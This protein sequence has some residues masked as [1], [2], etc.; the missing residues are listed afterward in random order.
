MIMMDQNTSVNALKKKAQDLGFDLVG[1]ASTADPALATEMERYHHW[2]DAGRGASMDYLRRHEPMKANPAL[3]L[4]G[5]RSVIAV[6]MVYGAEKPTASP[7]TAQI[8]L[9]AR[10][11]DY[12]D[13]LGTKLEELAAYARTLEA[14][15]A[16][17]TYVDKE[18]V[19][20]RFWA[21]RAGLGWLGKNTCLIN[22]K[23]GSFLFLGGV[24]TTLD[25][26]TDAPQP[27]HCGRC[28][29]CLDAC[30]TGALVEPH[31]LDAQLCIAY[32]TIENRGEVPPSVAE[33]PVSGY[34]AATSAKTCVRGTILS[35]RAAIFPWQTPHGASPSQ[36]LRCGQKPNSKS[37]CKALLF[38]GSN[39]P[40]SSAMLPLH[41][42]SLRHEINGEDFKQIYAGLIQ[43]NAQRVVA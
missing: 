7:D 22:R 21:W 31:V 43:H 23:V 14:G 2:V 17:R 24:M 37:L 16:T 30:P 27:D 29:K 33:K 20:D 3:F 38:L 34:S 25:L 35:H 1:V 4:P 9:Y 13:V 15:A 41:A 36:S 32:H 10:G 5:A 39:T 26:A 40:C 18:P 11:P 8:S 19:L 42:A 12:H 28:T 6:G